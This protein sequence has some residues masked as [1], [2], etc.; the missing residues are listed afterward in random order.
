MPADD[1][2]DGR[3]V[4]GVERV[5]APYIFLTAAA[6]VRGVVQG[7]SVRRE[8]GD[9]RVIRATRGSLISARRGGNRAGGVS[10]DPD[11]A[12]AGDGDVLGVLIP[13][14]AEIRAPQSLRAA[15]LAEIELDQ[16]GILGRAQRGVVSACRGNARRRRGG[17]SDV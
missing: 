7:G 14:A 5:R 17:A 11:A 4:G 15:A 16:I 3:S 6:Q 9:E 10:R 1:V 12:I 13:G 8:F 2:G